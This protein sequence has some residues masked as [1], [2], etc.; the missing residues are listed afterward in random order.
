MTV[1]GSQGSK[2]N[3]EIADDSFFQ[4]AQEIFGQGLE[5]LQKSKEMDALKLFG[6][7]SRLF[8]KSP[9]GVVGDA[10]CLSYSGVAFSQMEKREDLDAEAMAL[11]FSESAV[12]T[13]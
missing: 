11:L 9:S 10:L 4:E 8:R 6:E 1:Q 12:H 13:V 7:S 3:Q 2:K 5:M